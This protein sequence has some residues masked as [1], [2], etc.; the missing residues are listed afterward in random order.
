MNQLVLDL[1]LPAARAIVPLTVCQVL[2]DKDEDEA[3]SLVERG[4][5]RYAWN[6][7]SPN[8]DRREIRVLT[9]SLMSYLADP[10]RDPK[11]DEITEDQELMGEALAIQKACDPLNRHA[12]LT[13]TADLA[14][15]W[16]CSRTHILD[17]VAHGALQ[18]A[19]KSSSNNLPGRPAAMVVTAS[20]EKFLQRRRIL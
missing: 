11:A 4:K 9:A 13:R 12:R 6:I 20:A 3:L 5:L 19:G 17:L 14:R 10:L 7:A 8:A 1:N 18:G 2:C 15:Y 16:S